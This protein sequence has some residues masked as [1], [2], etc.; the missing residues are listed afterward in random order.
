[1]PKR[2]TLAFDVLELAEIEAALLIHLQEDLRGWPRDHTELDDEAWAQWYLD[3]H[4]DEAPLYEG[5]DDALGMA[6]TLY[7]LA[8]IRAA[9][10][11]AEG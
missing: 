4:R 6:T 2:V 10:A 5:D 7:L 9:L 1:M 8:K 3:E 11:V